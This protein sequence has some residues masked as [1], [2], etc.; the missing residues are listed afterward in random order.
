MRLTWTQRLVIMGFLL[1]ATTAPAPPS[2]AAAPTNPGTDTIT[3]AADTRT[4]VRELVGETLL[5]SQAYEYDRQLADLIGPRLTGSANFYKAVDWAEK[6]F[7]AL[8][9][10]SVHKEE[11][12]IPATWE[13]ETPANG[14]IVSPVDH[15]LHIFSLGW[16]P[17]TPIGG[18]TGKVVYIKQL[19][20]RKLKSKNLN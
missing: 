9:L 8:G 1:V 4:A 14:L 17:S 10:S 5:N 18:V 20:V 15:T 6:Q 13:P 12:T 11:W 19:T 7:K 16:S 3:I 2:A